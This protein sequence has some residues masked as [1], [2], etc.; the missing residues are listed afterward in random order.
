ML[1]LVLSAG[2]RGRRLQVRLRKRFLGLRLLCGAPA[3]YL[4]L[5]FI[6]ASVIYWHRDKCLAYSEVLAANGTL[7]QLGIAVGAAMLGVIGIVFSLSIFSIQQVA[8]RGTPLTLRE[9]ANDLV[10][11]LTY[12][13]L[14]AFAFLAMLSALG[15]RKESALYRVCVDLGILALSVLALKVYFDRVIKFVDPHYTI[16]KIAKR[17]NRSLRQIQRT[18]RAVQAELRYQ[19]TSRRRST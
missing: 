17:A 16:T 14:G 4:F 13:I 5:A 15:L 6:G 1:R 8:E 3:V 7:S 19:R 9:Y 12:W 10:F 2:V 11:V 18:E